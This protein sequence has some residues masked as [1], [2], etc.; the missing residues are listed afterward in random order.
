[1]WGKSVFACVDVGGRRIINKKKSVC[2]SGDVPFMY[3]CLVSLCLLV[4][5][6]GVLDSMMSLLH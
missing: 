1:M 6:F 3:T 2:V 5:S 4:C